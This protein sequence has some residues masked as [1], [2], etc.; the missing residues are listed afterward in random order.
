MPIK[1]EKCHPIRVREQLISA[2]RWPFD[3][4]LNQRW[5]RMGACVAQTGQGRQIPNCQLIHSTS[6]IVSGGKKMTVFVMKIS[7]ACKLKKVST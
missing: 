4:Y 6:I 2:S 1:L 5:M 7:A 3:F